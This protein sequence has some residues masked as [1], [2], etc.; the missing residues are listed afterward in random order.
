MPALAT[1]RKNLYR[2]VYLFLICEES[3]HSHDEWVPDLECFL[4][5]TFT[6][7]LIWLK[8][9]VEDL[10]FNVNPLLDHSPHIWSQAL[11]QKG[12]LLVQWQYVEPGCL[13]IRPKLG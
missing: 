6:G 5:D 3:I 2:F 4:D 10:G 1:L 8:R 7:F 12:L 13:K 11:P 9:V